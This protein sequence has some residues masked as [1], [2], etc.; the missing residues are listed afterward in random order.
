MTHTGLGAD[1][2]GGSFCRAWPHFCPDWGNRQRAQ[3]TDSA[4]A[5]GC[6]H[7]TEPAAPDTQPT[8]TFGLGPSLMLALPSLPATH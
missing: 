5:G 4:A 3:P 1:A 7:G 2:T 8:E 6:S